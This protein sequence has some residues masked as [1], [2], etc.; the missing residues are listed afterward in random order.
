MSSSVSV[1]EKQNICG[2]C[3]SDLVDP[4]FLPCFHTFC[5]RCLHRLT[6]LLQPGRSPLMCTT[7]GKSTVVPPAGRFPTNFYID[8]GDLQLSTCSKT[9]LGSSQMELSS[10]SPRFNRTVKVCEECE[11]PEEAVARCKNCSLLLCQDHYIGHRKSKVSSSHSMEDLLTG[12]EA[13]SLSLSLYKPCTKRDV[14][15]Q[16]SLDA[17]CETHKGQELKLYCS[18]CQDLICLY[19]IV[20]LH[21]EHQYDFI[22]DVIQSEKQQLVK[23]CS[24]VQPLIQ[25]LKE[26]IDQIDLLQ[27]EIQSNKQSFIQQHNLTRDSTEI[28]A[29]QN[30]SLFKQIKLQRQKDELIK[31]LVNTQGSLSFIQ[32]MLLKGSPSDILSYKKSSV[33]RLSELLHLLSHTPLEPIEDGNFETFDP[34]ESIQISSDIFS[35]ST[36]AVVTQGGKLSIEIGCN[37][38]TKFEDWQHLVKATWVAGEIETN[39]EVEKLNGEKGVV[40]VTAVDG[41]KIMVQVG[42]VNIKGSPVRIAETKKSA[43]RS[44]VRETE[45]TGN[46]GYSDLGKTPTSIG[47]SKL[48]PQLVLPTD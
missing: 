2:V 11:I 13:S 48:A 32:S 35:I 27:S 22:E 38:K 36:A 5:S 15:E 10:R 28:H 18:T 25:R 20:K 44:V 41:G 17:L 6:Y 34:T 46:S 33:Q 23:L 42:G 31:S 8:T 3:S 29:I 30:K 43:K 4:C 9:S 26:A 1:F 39:L 37:I 47:R 12:H 14:E 24:E 19:C 7:C 40:K 21:R 16:H 45:E